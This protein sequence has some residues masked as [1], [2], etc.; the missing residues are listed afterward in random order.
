MVSCSCTVCAT[1]MGALLLKIFLFEHFHIAVLI[2]YSW[3]A[4]EPYSTLP[5]SNLSLSDGDYFID[6]I[7]S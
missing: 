5:V 1:K 3:R 7:R 4:A 2:I 6:E